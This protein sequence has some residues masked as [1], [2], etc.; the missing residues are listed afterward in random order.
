MNL[1]NVKIIVTAVVLTIYALGATAQE[2]NPDDH[3]KGMRITAFNID[4]GFNGSYAALTVDDYLK[5]KNTAVDQSQFISNPQDYN[6]SSYSGSGGSFAPSIS[7]GFTPY[8]KK[9]G[10]HNYNRE[11]RIKLGGSFGGRRSFFFSQDEK[12]AYDTLSSSIGNPDIFI[13]SVYY[14]NRNYVETI[15]EINIG[16]SYLFKTNASKR[17]HLYAGVGAEYGFAFQNYVSIN[18]D[19]GYYLSSYYSPNYYRD[20][21]DNYTY[22]S[23]KSKL[24]SNTHFVRLYIP[25]GIN[26]RIAND[27][28]SFKHVNL[29]T[30]F[31]PGLE[32]QI[33][34]GVETYTNP[35]IGVAVIGFRYTFD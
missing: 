19:E 32:F 12:F 34:T 26:F 24:T 29:Y 31:S 5:M 1:S 3:K 4:F 2:T 17:W 16:V 30:Q 13:D 27:N 33:V 6:L 10:A 21:N 11:L 20:T 25:L 8:S 23:S 7:L 14:N 28:A 15:S 35:F 9:L 22:N 18:N